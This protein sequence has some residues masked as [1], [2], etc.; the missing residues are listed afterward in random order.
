MK[1]AILLMVMMSGMTLYAQKIVSGSLAP[2]NHETSVNLDVDFAKSYI[3]G[4]TEHDYMSREKE[5]QDWKSMFINCVMTNISEIAEGD[6]T[7]GKVDGAEYLII[8]VVDKLDEKGNVKCRAELRDR[9]GVVLCEIGELSGSGSWLGF[10]SLTQE[11]MCNGIEDMSESLGHFLKRQ[12]RK[13]KKEEKRGK[14]PG[15]GAAPADSQKIVA[16][17]QIRKW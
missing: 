12:L 2:L 13:M 17:K 15:M 8:V 5:W 14:I 3:E 16:P 9:D 7:I 6:C 1:Y 11:L 4:L 10:G